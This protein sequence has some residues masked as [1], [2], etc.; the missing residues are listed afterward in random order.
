MI[1]KNISKNKI[2]ADDLLVAD[3]FFKRFIGLMFKKELSLGRGLHI[4]PCNSIHMCFM[5][6]PLDII[7]LNRNNEIV[8]IIEGIKPW[9]FTNIIPHAYSVLELPEGTIDITSSY[10]GD[11]IIF[12]PPAK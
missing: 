1:A 11:K 4:T 3:S 6:F 2:L 10:V 5:N 7:F 9:K 8:S 12:Y